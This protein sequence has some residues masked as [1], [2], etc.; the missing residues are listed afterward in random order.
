MIHIG[1]H[2]FGD[3]WLRSYTTIC[4]WYSGRDMYSV[5]QQVAPHPHKS[6]YNVSPVSGNMNVRSL[7]LV[8]LHFREPRWWSYGCK[9]HLKK[10]SS[11][12]RGYLVDCFLGVGFYNHVRLRTLSNGSMRY[13]RRPIQWLRADPT[14]S[15]WRAWPSGW[16]D[17]WNFKLVRLVS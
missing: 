2:F 15:V 14:I 8:R 7:E 4:L 17:R 6:H 13:V 12:W 1:V 16:S 10:L 3:A 11:R 5:V 9:I